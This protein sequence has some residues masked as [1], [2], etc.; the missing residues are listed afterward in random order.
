[1]STLKACIA[2]QVA[3]HPEFIPTPHNAEALNRLIQHHLKKGWEV[4]TEMIEEAIRYGYERNCFETQLT[5]DPNTGV[6]IRKRGEG[7]FAS[8][9]IMPE[10]CIWADE[11]A[12]LIQQEA[13]EAVRLSN[14]EAQRAIALPFVELQKQVRAGF[15]RG[16]T[17]ANLEGEESVR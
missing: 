1:M 9:P 3:Q 2:V 6:V 13:E 5:R 11:E 16:R 7:F 14:E 15:K 10:R 4:S 8:P 17:P 12:L